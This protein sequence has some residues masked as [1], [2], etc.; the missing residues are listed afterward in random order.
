MDFAEKGVQVL[1]VSQ[2]ESLVQTTYSPAPQVARQALPL[3][4]FA[5]FLPGQT[6]ST[7]GS[8]PKQQTLP[9]GQ[10]EDSLHAKSA[11]PGRASQA[12]PSGLH[13]L[14]LFAF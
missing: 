9:V 6:G 14:A 10:S 3:T 5:K 2:S 13:V 7:L 4:P 12:V 8:P 1:P 11:V